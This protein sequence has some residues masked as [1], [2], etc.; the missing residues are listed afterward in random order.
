MHKMSNHLVY[1]SKSNRANPDHVMLVRRH[2]ESLGYDILEHQGGTYDPNLMLKCRY[3]IIVGIHAPTNGNSGVVEI[4]KG[5]YQ[6][7]THRRN[8][9]TNYYHAYFSHT[10][11]SSTS[12]REVPVY[13]SVTEGGVIDEK[14]WTTGYGQL[15]VNMST[16]RKL[17]MVTADK[18]L[19]KTRSTLDGGQD[20][21]KQADITVTVDNKR[22]KIRLACIKL[23]Y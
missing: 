12:G 2:L 3:M 11:K 17:P 6:Q 10:A 7:L 8:L 23:F 4:G 5:Q 20:M 15:L 14:N 9:S 22:R 18:M 13:R 19:R 21:M 16:M 1:L